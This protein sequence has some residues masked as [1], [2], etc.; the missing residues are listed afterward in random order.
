MISS[1]S[2]EIRKCDFSSPGAYGSMRSTDLG[3]IFHSAVRQ[4]KVILQ[5]DI[6]VT[7][8]LKGHKEELSFCI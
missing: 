3:R 2:K 4:S 7:H 8:S 6:L 1:V 5:W